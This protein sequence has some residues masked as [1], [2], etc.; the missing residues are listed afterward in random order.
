MKKVIIGIV[1]IFTGVFFIR[2][3]I[4]AYKEY[5]TYGIM[6]L[7][8]VP[9]IIQVKEIILGLVS[10]FIGI[11]LIKDKITSNGLVSFLVT[12]ILLEV[13][14]W[15]FELIRYQ[16]VEMMQ[17]YLPI[18]VVIILILTTIKFCTKTRV[19]K[20]LMKIMKGQIKRDLLIGSLFFGIVLLISSIIDYQFI[21][22]LR[23]LHNN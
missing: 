12:V 1:W 21:E 6:W 10:M 9:E 14:V 7:F 20:N 3:G 13:E 18:L 16:S 15:V 17:F 8:V 22:S 4:E 5:S 19:Y 11:R 2:E 23:Q